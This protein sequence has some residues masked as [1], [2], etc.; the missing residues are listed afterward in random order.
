M[1]ASSGVQ[2]GSSSQT[3][4]IDSWQYKVQDSAIYEKV[5]TTLKKIKKLVGRNL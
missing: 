5:Q 2:S 4:R 1:R 3:D